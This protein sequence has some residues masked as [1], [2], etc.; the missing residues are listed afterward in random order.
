MNEHCRLSLTG[1]TTFLSFPL[2]HLLHS[3]LIKEHGEFLSPPLG[4]KG[5]V[6]VCVCW[7]CGDF[8]ARHP[9]SV[10][11]P[12]FALAISYDIR[13]KEHEQPH[14]LICSGN[15]VLGSRPSSQTT[16]SSFVILFLS[17]V[18]CPNC[19]LCLISSLYATQIK[20]SCSYIAQY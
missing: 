12:C 14:S 10:A 5:S 3:R 8:L 6:C 9:K 13:P 16:T 2:S 4:W 7:R 15:V 19:M 11:T 20:L 1:C 18:P 17:L